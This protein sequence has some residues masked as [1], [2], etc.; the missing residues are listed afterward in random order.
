MNIKSI[1]SISAIW[2]AM[3]NADVHHH[4]TSALGSLPAGIFDRGEPAA[5]ANYHAASIIFDTLS[6]R[7]DMLGRAYVTND[8]P[9]QELVFSDNTGALRAFADIAP[10]NVEFLAA[11]GTMPENALIWGISGDAA[12]ALAAHLDAVGFRALAGQIGVQANGPLMGMNLSALDS[13]NPWIDALGRASAVYLIGS[14]LVQAW[15]PDTLGILQRGVSAYDT[16]AGLALSEVYGNGPDM[17]AQAMFFSHDYASGSLLGLDLEDMAY[18][19]AALMDLQSDGKPKAALAFVFADCDEAEAILTAFP[20]RIDM[21]AAPAAR[22]TTLQTTN[23]CVAEIMLDHDGQ[24][25]D[26][27]ASFD[28][29]YR[30]LITPAR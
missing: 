20:Q 17:V 26:Q 7:A 14:T 6:L 2:P 27:N 9:V 21:T 19:G 28:M 22:Y 25:T 30:A 15:A 3:A 10:Y 5:F 23:A 1:I 29:V 4:F 18:T 12:P 13:D 11:Y 8:A 16:T 24:D